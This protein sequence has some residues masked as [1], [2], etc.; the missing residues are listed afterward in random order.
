[1][2]KLQQTGSMSDS[3]CKSCGPASPGAE[4]SDSSGLECIVS[5]ESDKQEK[6]S[7]KKGKGQDVSQSFVSALSTKIDELEKSIASSNQLERENAKLRRKHLREVQKYVSDR[8]LTAEDRLQFLQSRYTQQATD[9]LKTEKQYFEVVKEMD[10]VTR[11]KDKVQADLKKANTLKDKLEELCR[12]L[13][14]EVKEVAEESKRRNEEELKQRQV[15]QQ[16]FTQAINDVSAKMDQHQQER[17]KQIAENDALRDRLNQFL[18]QF[19]LQEKQ[20]NQQM[21]AKDLEV[22]LMTAKLEQQLQIN[23]QLAQKSSLLQQTNDQLSKAHDTF[24][25]EMDSFSSTREQNLLLAES[26]KELKSQ[27][28]HYYEKFAEFQTTLTKSNQMFDKLKS[29]LENHHTVRVQLQKERDELKRKAEKSDVTIIQLLD[30]KTTLKKQVE[31]LQGKLQTSPDADELRRLKTQKE[32]LEGLCRTLTAQLK[33]QTPA[34]ETT[35]E[36]IT[37]AQQNEA[38]CAPEKQTENDQ[39][40]LGTTASSQEINLPDNLY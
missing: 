14:R 32:R 37:D 8:S 28:E 18:E 27:L 15:L 40:Q 23:T 10:A 17:M 22:Q 6:I 33:S 7:K 4:R 5:D 31:K 25:K 24:S 19:E 34:P 2:P 35:S 3:N 21:H 13:Q 1:M 39:D 38:S 20:Y 9:L 36:A 11:E 16:R 26:N 12:Q 30:E 29:E